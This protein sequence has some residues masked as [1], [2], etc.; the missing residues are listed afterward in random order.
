[1]LRSCMSSR[2]DYLPGDVFD[3]IRPH[4]VAACDK[5]IFGREEMVGRPA[6]TTEGPLLADVV[7]LRRHSGQRQWGY[8]LP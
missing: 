6:Q 3:E 2:R 8:L 1:M 5:V 4:V 7:S